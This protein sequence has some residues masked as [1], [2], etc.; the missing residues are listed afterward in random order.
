MSQEKSLDERS[1]VNDLEE[2]NE[3]QR[4]VIVEHDGRA[5][6]LVSFGGFC[7]RNINSSFVPFFLRYYCID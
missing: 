7:V 1:C 5:A 2:S 3:V 4:K 6:W